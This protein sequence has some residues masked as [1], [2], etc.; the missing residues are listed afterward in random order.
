MDQHVKL[1]RSVVLDDDDDGAVAEAHGTAAER[2]L[3]HSHNSLHQG[4]SSDDPGHISV[5][6]AS[7]RAHA[8]EQGIDPCPSNHLG[9]YIV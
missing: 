4:A 9:F 5:T 3:L 7:C 2:F 6:T 1:P 8:V